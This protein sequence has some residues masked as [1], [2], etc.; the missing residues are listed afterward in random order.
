MANSKFFLR[1]VLF[2][3]SAF[4]EPISSL[5]L[6]IILSLPIFLSLPISFSSLFLL[7]SLLSS[8]FIF[9]S[10]PILFFSLFGG[11]G[12]VQIRCVVEVKVV[13]QVT[14]PGTNSN[15]SPTRRTKCRLPF[16]KEESKLRSSCSLAQNKNTLF[17]KQGQ[18]RQQRLKAGNCFKVQSCSP[19]HTTQ[20]SCLKRARKVSRLVEGVSK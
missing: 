4:L 2:I 10:L 15:S 7:Y 11:K 5:F 14:Q 20:L 8:Y 3:Q 17:S 12:K 13:Q 1:E 19:R 16:P 9:L 6:P 18:P